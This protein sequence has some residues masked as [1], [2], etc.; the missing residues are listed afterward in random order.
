MLAIGVFWVTYQRVF[1]YSHGLDS[2]TPEFETVFMGL[3]RF[4]VVANAIFFAISIGWIWST[5]DRK[6]DVELGGCDLEQ[7]AQE[8]P[9]SVPQPDQSQ[10]EVGLLS[11]EGRGA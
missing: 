10:R 2:M 5:R 1:G 4:N 11:G 8:H 7:R 3:W 9:G 6:P